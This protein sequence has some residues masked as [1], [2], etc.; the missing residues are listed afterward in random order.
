MEF[1]CVELGIQVR[2]HSREKDMIYFFI[3]NAR[4]IGAVQRDNRPGW[5]FR[6]NYLFNNFFLGM[7]L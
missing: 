2:R 1:L 6:Y 3:K 7:R 5:Q 4:C